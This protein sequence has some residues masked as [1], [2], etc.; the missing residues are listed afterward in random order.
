MK[1]NKVPSLPLKTKW[2]HFKPHPVIGVDEAGRGC[3]AGPVFS[4]AVILKTNKSYPDSKQISPK[5]RQSLAQEIMQN[6]LYAI[7]MS[8]VQEIEALNILQASLLAM[9]RAIL[10][11]SVLTGHVLVDGKFI[12]TN[13]P[14]TFKQSPFIKGDQRFSPIAAA[15]IL[16][17]V[18][19]DIWICEQD[20]KYP[21]YGFTSHKGYGTSKHR[22]AIAKHGPCPL[23]R[24][25]F[26]GV[27]EYL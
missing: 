23:H 1:M 19:R 3:L 21:Q 4:A 2:N 15:S 8:Q 16:A 6:N 9:K 14:D 13:L 24:K 7:G 18:K 10:K 25:S 20:I 12:V 22:K 26:A 27:R 11:L 5:K 17:K